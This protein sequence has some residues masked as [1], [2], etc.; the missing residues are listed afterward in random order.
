M[1]QK[2][3]SLSDNITCINK[4]AVLPKHDFLVLICPLQFI[5]GII[6][7]CAARCADAPHRPTS[8]RNYDYDIDQL[9]KLTSPLAMK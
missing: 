5:F 1:I 2:L 3:I 4:K 9:S 6:S 7:I 8:K